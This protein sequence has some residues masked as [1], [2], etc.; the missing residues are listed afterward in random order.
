MATHGTPNVHELR[1]T[2]GATYASLEHI[3]LE[4]ANMRIARYGHVLIVVVGPFTIQCLPKRYGLTALEMK[5]G[6]IHWR[7]P[8]YRVIA[9]RHGVG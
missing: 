7:V 6:G 1:L 5:P 9:N 2:H 4:E 8:W 3:S